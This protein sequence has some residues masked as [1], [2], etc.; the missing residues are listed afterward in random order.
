M[1]YN[2]DEGLE[3]GSMKKKLIILIITGVLLVIAGIIF[4]IFG[5]I[6]VTLNNGDEI[7]WTILNDYK[8]P[9]FMITKYEKELNK[10]KYTYEIESNVDI[11]KLGTY[12]VKYN[13]KYFLYTYELERIV[14]VVDDVKPEIITNTETLIKDYCTKKLTNKLEY[15]ANDNYDGELTDKVLEEETEEGVILKVTDSSGNEQVK[16]ILYTLSEKPKDKFTLVGNSTIYVSKGTTYKDQGTSYKDGCGNKVDVKVSTSGSVDTSKNGEY[17]ITYKA[18]D[19]TLTRKVVVYTPSSNSGGNPSSKV[20]YLTFDDGPCSYTSRVLDTLNK[21]NVKATF[22]VTHQ[23]SGYVS[24]I[25]KEYEPGHSVAVH[26]YTHNWNIYKSVDAYVNDFNKMQNDIITYTGN[27]S[28]I[29]RFPGG[30]SNTVSRS[31]AKGVVKAIASK[32]TSLGYQYFDWDVDSGDAAGASRSKIYSNVVNG[33]KKCSKCIVLMHDIKSNTVNEL[34]H[35][36]STLTS[37]G[38]R[39][40]T[41]S[42]NSPTVHHKIAN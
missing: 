11:T 35:I 30:S 39:F 26:S 8:D 6:K 31:Y 12:S 18:N 4:L 13:I 37:Q 9:G 14:H 40:G 17:K 33:V 32:M 42:V 21:Y 41:L 25:K 15:T 1:C 10:D 7:N 22:F 34:D 3:V 24:L 23:F 5:G 36:L 2:I 29:F 16:N 19:L 27:K 28:Y 20:I 38:Y